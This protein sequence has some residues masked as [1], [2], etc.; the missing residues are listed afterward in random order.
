MAMFL[1]SWPILS[2]LNVH[3]FPSRDIHSGLFVYFRTWYPSKG[4]LPLDDVIIIMCDTIYFGS[5]PRWRDNCDVNINF[6]EKIKSIRWQSFERLPILSNLIRFVLRSD[7][8]VIMYENM[9]LQVTMSWTEVSSGQVGKHLRN[10][11]RRSWKRQ[12]TAGGSPMFFVHVSGSRHWRNGSWPSVTSTTCDLLLLLLLLRSPS[13]H[14]FCNIPSTWTFFFS[15]KN[16]IILLFRIAQLLQHG[17]R[18][19]LFDN[20]LRR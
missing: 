15:K 13:L 11:L 6:L 16:N 20:F 8:I 7:G 18:L 3:C 5:T 1:K 10:S 12:K 17:I 14:N 4:S 19:D 9:S 2:S